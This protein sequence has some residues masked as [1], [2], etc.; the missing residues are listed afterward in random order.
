MSAFLSLLALYEDGAALGTPPSSQCAVRMSHEMNV[1]VLFPSPSSD[2][3][4]GS[5]NMEDGMEPSTN[6]L[7]KDGNIRILVNVNSV[8]V[9][10]SLFLKLYNLLSQ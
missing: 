4:R 2:V 1:S 8:T 9:L 3:I 6:S 10:W 7:L 5:V